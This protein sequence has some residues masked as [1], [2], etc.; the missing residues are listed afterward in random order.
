MEYGSS[1]AHRLAR[2]AGLEILHLLV[3]VLLLIPALY[4]FFYVLSFGQDHS[5]SSFLKFCAGMWRDAEGR[6]ILPQLGRG[7]GLSLLLI[8]GSLAISIPLSVA[9]GWW[10]SIN[11]KASGLKALLTVVSSVPAFAFAYV[12]QQF[13]NALFFP[14]LTLAISD[15]MLSVAA[16]HVMKEM[17]VEVRRNYVRTAVAKGVSPLRHYWRRL[18]VEILCVTKSRI[19]YL[20]GGTVVV[21]RIFSLRGLGNMAVL[22]VKR[23]PPDLSILL[24]IC[25]I[26]VLAVYV[27]NLFE[28]LARDALMPSPIEEE[29]RPG[30]AERG[31]PPGRQASFWGGL[32]RL[33]RPVLPRHPHGAILGEPVR[34]AAAAQRRRRCV[35]RNVQVRLEEMLSSSPLNQAK[36]VLGVMIWLAALAGLLA[37]LAAGFLSATEALGRTA[38]G[39]DALGMTLLAGQRL[40][41]PVLLGVL[42]PIVLGVILG[43]YGGYFRYSLL[44]RAI[45]YAMDLLD[46]MPKLVL[47]M[48][49]AVMVSGGAFYLYKV[50]PF[51]GFTFTPLIYEHVRKKVEY[52]QRMNFVET[53]RALGAG[54]PRILFLHILYNNCR[55]II[56]VHG[57]HLLGQ[58]VL[59][60]AAFDYLGLA[61]PEHYTWGA[62]FYNSIYDALMGGEA[63]PWAYLAP[64]GAILLSVLA[65]TTLSDG[66]AAILEPPLQE[67][68]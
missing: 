53:E 56:S 63:N 60:D 43:A 25:L 49:F 31:R 58:I 48:M 67:A 50:I 54:T 11:V 64:L 12:F 36:F 1:L 57:V 41:L 26:S 35:P 5:L 47:V 17:S 37:V 46:A 68:T 42:I 59:L 65:L 66:L 27:L 38:T 44:S 14:I 28:A 3:I 18:V 15:L 51:M 30:I 13:S 55:S 24:W 8:A 61:Q 39:Q 7:L 20:I 19:A 4:L 29:V 32:A 6:E 52:L 22:A 16:S 45:K 40:L 10:G 23:T 33:F 34:P 2:R 21:E 62:L 9:V